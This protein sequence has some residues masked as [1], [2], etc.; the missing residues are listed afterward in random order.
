MAR[1]LLGLFFICFYGFATAQ[2]VNPKDAIAY[3]KAGEE[4][5]LAGNG[6]QALRLFKK[7]VKA[8]PDFNAARRGLALCLELNRDYKAAAKEYKTILDRD[9]LFSRIMYFQAGEAFYKAGEPET[10]LGYFR[11]YESLQDWKADTFSL[12]TERELE[13]EEEYL[14][15]LSGSIRACEV[16]LD[17][18][19][20]I[21][22]TTVQS[23]G[24]HVNT[25]AD[26]YFPFL[27]NDQERLYFT[28]KTDNG[29]E[30]L[31]ESLFTDGQWT[32][33]R[34]VR[35][36][37]SNNDEGM[38]TFVRDGRVL[39]YTVCGREGV[40]GGCDIWQ[41]EMDKDREVTSIAPLEGFANSDGWESQAA[42]SCDGQTLF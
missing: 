18:I 15:R 29:D 25:K 31:Y 7:A 23:L 20:F 21:N 16:S 40:L 39:F 32:K 19:K 42:I 4:A 28:R 10:A 12:N 6:D 26:D 34:A 38:S 30:D 27:T 33:G 9:T 41:A 5:L 17:S 2:V 3:Y 35:A 22:I 1:I 8:K 24:G 36:L 11:E 14:R 37:N 13:L